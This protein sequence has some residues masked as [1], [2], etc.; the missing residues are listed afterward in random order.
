MT[1][2]GKIVG[3]GEL[4]ELEDKEEEEK[5]EEEEEVDLSDAVDNNE[6]LAVPDFPDP[7][8]VESGYG[9]SEVVELVAQQSTPPRPCPA[10]PAQ[11]Q[12]LPFCSQRLTSVKPSYRSF[13][14]YL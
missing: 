14:E 3:A 13:Q 2:L 12:L 4:V 6:V 9:S 10:V 7:S 8:I 5:E 11:H 1:E